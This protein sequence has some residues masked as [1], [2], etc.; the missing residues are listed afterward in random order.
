MPLPPPTADWAFFSSP[1]SFALFSK[2]WDCRPYR[3]AAIGSGTGEVIRAAGFE[4]LVPKS[5]DTKKAAAEF[6][7]HVKS[8]EIVMTPIGNKSFRRLK[9]LIP[10][11]RLREYPCYRTEARA[12]IPMVEADYFIFTSPS[13]A[14]AFQ[15][16]HL[17]RAGQ[18]AVA[19]GNST[20]AA[21]DSTIWKK[22]FLSPHPDEES[23]WE[24]IRTQAST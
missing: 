21:L 14:D 23:L 5:S 9:G 7:N 1:G 13:N 15:L 17:P 20:F 3:L 8:T 22:V 11:E 12:E 6:A 18:Y 16:A 24:I 19:M 4:V 10:A 2:K